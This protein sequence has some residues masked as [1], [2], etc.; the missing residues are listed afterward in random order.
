LGLP[1]TETVLLAKVKDVVTASDTG[2]KG[3]WTE[4][5]TESLDCLIVSLF[6]SEAMSP[7]GEFIFINTTKYLQSGT[8]TLDVGVLAAQDIDDPKIWL[9]R[10]FPYPLQDEVPV[11]FKRI[12]ASWDHR[13][14]PVMVKLSGWLAL[15]D[16]PTIPGRVS[17]DAAKILADIRGRLPGGNFSTL[18]QAPAFKSQYALH[19]DQV[20]DAVAIALEQH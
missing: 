6:E 8:A 16:R 15:I 11:V 7:E 3:D 5:R 12:F 4:I 17:E 2:S 19:Y 10:G 13:I 14:D 18:Q 1:A 9:V 20:A